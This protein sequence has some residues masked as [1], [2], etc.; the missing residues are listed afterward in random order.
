MSAGPIL[1]LRHYRDDLIAHSHDH[2]QLVF[3]LHGRL[4]F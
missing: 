1:S 3:G 4:D 2:P